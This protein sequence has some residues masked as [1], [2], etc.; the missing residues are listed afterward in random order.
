MNK[1]EIIIEEMKRILKILNDDYFFIGYK[2]ALEDK[3]LKLANE[4]EEI[5]THQDA[6]NKE[7]SKGIYKKYINDLRNLWK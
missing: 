4:L 2:E 7:D 3:Y 5:D 6:V 1:R